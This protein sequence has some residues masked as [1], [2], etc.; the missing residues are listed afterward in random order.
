VTILLQIFSWFLQW[1]NCENRLIF[2][3]VKAYKGIVPMFGPPCSR[4]RFFYLLSF[5]VSYPPSSLNGIQTKPAIHARKWVPFDSV[6][7]K[8]EVY[9]L[10]IGGPKITYFR[11]LRNLTTTLTACIFGMKHEIDNRTSALETTRVPSS[12]QNVMVFEL[13][14]KRLKTGPPFYPPSVNSAF[15]SIANLPRRRS[16]NGIQP[17]L[18][19]GGH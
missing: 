3:K 14:H 11:W 18:P 1:N 19:N 15:Y 12:S 16:A 7:P 9:P 8:S 2:G 5:F 13:V 6:C 4:R 10:Q 17:T